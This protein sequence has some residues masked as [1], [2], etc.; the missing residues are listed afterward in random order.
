MWYQQLV[1]EA[2]MSPLGHSCNA[3]LTRHSTRGAMVDFPR[4]AAHDAVRSPNT[5]LA[6]ERGYAVRCLLALA[7]EHMGVGRQRDHWRGVT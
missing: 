6:E 7:S 4:D 1:G 3:V 5:A 2:S